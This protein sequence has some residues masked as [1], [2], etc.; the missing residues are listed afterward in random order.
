MFVLSVVCLFV[1]VSGGCQRATE[2][3][4]SRS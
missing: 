2:E 1:A 4:L 3:L